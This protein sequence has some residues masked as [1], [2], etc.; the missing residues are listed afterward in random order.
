[1]VTVRLIVS[2]IIQFKMCDLY[3]YSL[4]DVNLPFTRNKQDQ[5]FQC[6]YYSR[7]SVDTIMRRCSQSLNFYSTFTMFS[8]FCHSIHRFLFIM[9]IKLPQY[10]PTERSTSKRWTQQRQQNGDDR[11]YHESWFVNTYAR[12]VSNW[13]ETLKRVGLSMD[14]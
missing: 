11:K 9:H 14:Q 10:L 12:L 2:E 6:S 5:H 8:V 7:L 4:F 3:K 13:S 1:M